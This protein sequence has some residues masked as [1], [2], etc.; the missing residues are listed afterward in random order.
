MVSAAVFAGFESNRKVLVED[1]ELF[2]ASGGKN[3][4]SVVRGINGSNENNHGCRCSEL[5]KTLWLC[6]A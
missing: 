1:E 4:R 2:A 6:I 3:L 5:D